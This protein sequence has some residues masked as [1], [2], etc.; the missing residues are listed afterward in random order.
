MSTK[1]K[2]PS[3]WAYITAPRPWAFA[4]TITPIAL[5]S[6]VCYK[7]TGYFDPLVIILTSI[8]VI[9]I[10]AA[11]NLINTYYD[12][13]KGIDS[14]GATD[15][16]LV[17]KVLKPKDVLGLAAFCYALG[18]LGFA[19]L[20][21]VSSA[22]L[23]QLGW[24]FCGGIFSSFFYTGGLSLKY[25]GL[26]D[27]VILVT[28]GPLT[29]LISYVAQCGSFSMTP[30][31]YTIPLVLITEAMLHSNNA[32]DMKEDKESGIVTLAILLGE[33]GSYIFY[34]FLI[35]TPYV[36]IIVMAVNYSWIFLLPFV[37]L[38]IPFDLAK[39][40]AEKKLDMPKRTAKLNFCLGL[41]Y[42][43]SC[44]LARY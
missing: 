9:G 22:T 13:I 39:C 27:V 35:F 11:G 5:G 36:T 18:S 37:T 20:L 29:V 31:Y 19:A 44:L 16:T 24:Y 26:G 2:A 7:R 30:V 38:Q 32:R 34:I 15:K 33:K 10:Q 23:Q 4:A 17:E 41:L 12:Y 1:L 40:F 43:L 25:H 21:A 42:V 14:E 28:F 3:L 8:T 6:V